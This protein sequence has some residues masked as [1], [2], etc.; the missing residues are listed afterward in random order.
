MDGASGRVSDFM[1][2]SFAEDMICGVLCSASSIPAPVTI[3]FPPDILIY[4]RR[5][6][7]ILK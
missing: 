5:F 6:A 7:N 1:K 3:F 4:G 2:Y